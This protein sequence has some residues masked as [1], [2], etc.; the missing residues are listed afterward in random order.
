[1][2][3]LE[4]NL[5]NNGG[6]KTIVAGNWKMNLNLEQVRGLVEGI[7]ASAPTHA[8]V[9]VILAPAYPHLA[10]VAGLIKKK[11]PQYSTNSDNNDLDSGLNSDLG[12]SPIKVAAQD[13]H[14]QDNG[15]FTGKVSVSMIKDLGADY[16]IVGHSEQREHFN[17]TNLLINLKVKKLLEGGLS[18]ILCVGETLEQREAG[19]LKAILTQQLQEGLKDI[20]AE[21]M[22]RIIIAYEPVW[23]IGTGKSAT[24]SE[25]DEAHQI[26]RDILKE[27]FAGGPRVAPEVADKVANET[28]ILY[29][30]S[31]KAGNAQ[32]LFQKKNING[33]LVGGASLKSEEFIGII[34]A[35]VKVYNN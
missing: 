27:I 20:S 17:E 18:P 25:A 29:G 26:V 21:E 24:S 31:V 1:M 9:Q 22:Q 2:G 8:Q 16:S 28:F 32:E 10:E 13:V 35:A 4:A 23:A 6:R 5:G 14:Y 12:S 3:N 30:G 34:E 15:A 7:T 19:K 11:Y 33:G